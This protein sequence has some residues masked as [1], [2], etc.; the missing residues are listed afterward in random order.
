M[1]FSLLVAEIAL[2]QEI[3]KDYEISNTCIIECNDEWNT[4]LTECSNADDSAICS[5]LC[6]LEMTECQNNCPCMS[7]CP[8]GCDDCKVGYFSEF[9]R[10]QRVQ[11]LNFSLR[12]FPGVLPPLIKIEL[13]PTLPLGTLS[14]ARCTR[15]Y[16]HP[17]RVNKTYEIKTVRTP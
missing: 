2:G 14:S 4:C 15:C 10:V 7:N 6:S 17:Y 8:N 1:K 11:S 16:V 3:C 9:K 5:H 12:V 13:V